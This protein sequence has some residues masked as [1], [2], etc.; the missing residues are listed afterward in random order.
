MQTPASSSSA[1][2]L[3][4]D[5]F[6]LAH[7]PAVGDR[8]PVV[9]L[10]FV[11]ASRRIAVA[12]GS[13][14]LLVVR[15]QRRRLEPHLLVRV[16]REVEVDR[17]HRPGF[18]RLELQ[19]RRVEVEAI[20][21]ASRRLLHPR[22][23]AFGQDGLEHTP[24]RADLDQQV[25]RSFVGVASSV[26]SGWIAGWQYLIARARSWRSCGGVGKPIATVALPG[27]GWSVRRAPA[28][29]SASPRRT[30]PPQRAALACP[31]RSPRRSRVPRH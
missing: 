12:V 6:R 14:D 26:T 24:V 11:A 5:D 16:A 30:G 8:D 19:A 20:L 23:D 4:V 28:R 1:S 9:D 31:A 21:Q 18:H 17:H 27:T 25:E 7:P 2:P 29:T 10:H 15:T 13:E 3:D 22:Q